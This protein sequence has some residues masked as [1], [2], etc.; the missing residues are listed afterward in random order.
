MPRLVRL[1]CDDRSRWSWNLLGSVPRGRHRAY[2]QRLSP[3][4]GALRIAS[5]ALGVPRVPPTLHRV[6]VGEDAAERLSVVQVGIV[7]RDLAPAVDAAADEAR[8]V[9]V[10]EHEVLAQVPQHTPGA[11]SPLVP[12]VVD[13]GLVEVGDPGQP[14]T[15][16]RSPCDVAALLPG[17]AHLLRVDRPASLGD[18]GVEPPDGVTRLESHRGHGFGARSVVRRPAYAEETP[19]SLRVCRPGP[20]RLLVAA[21]NR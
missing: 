1:A 19:R 18:V 7:D 15:L 14:V 17:G 3:K 16:E 11:V 21:A 8:G 9:N 4:A 13:V 2:P 10:V 5:A 20:Q 12:G 6:G